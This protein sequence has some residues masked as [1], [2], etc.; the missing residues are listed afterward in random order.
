M[1]PVEPQEDTPQPAHEIPPPP[2]VA[3]TAGRAVGEPIIAN[4]FEYEAPPLQPGQLAP[5]W[6]TVFITGWVLVLAGFGCIWQAGRVAGIAPW[7]LGP[8]SDQRL[9]LVIALP[10]VAP[11]IAV[12]MAAANLRAAVYFGLV[13]GVASTTVALGDLEY[14]GLALGEVAIGLSGLLVS[15]ACLVGRMRQPTALTPQ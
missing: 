9:F 14:P 12:L 5:G 3:E 1:D 11:L 7:W 10:F 6:K 4:P 8:E 13:A 15:I 2:S